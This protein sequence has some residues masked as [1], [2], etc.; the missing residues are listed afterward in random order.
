MLPG[1]EG[2]AELS[3]LAGWPDRLE[4]ASDATCARL[5]C[6]GAHLSRAGKDRRPAESTQGCLQRGTRMSCA[7]R[8]FNER[9]GQGK[10][11]LVSL[12]GSLPAVLSSCT[13]AMARTLHADLVKHMDSTGAAHTHL[14]GRVTDR[15]GR[16]FGKVGGRLILRF[17]SCPSAMRTGASNSDLHA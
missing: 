13:A 1:R 5:D 15:P 14:T 10:P 17:V 3:A 8:L 2:L 12:H 11:R 7:Q 9:S 4:A 16:P 6:P